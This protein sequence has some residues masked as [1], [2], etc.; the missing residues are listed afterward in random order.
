MTTEDLDRTEESG[1]ALRAKLEAEIAKNKA[2]A[3]V[4]AS[5]VA[6][7]H[8]YVK[9]EDLAGV[10]PTQLVEKATEIE[11]KRAAEREELL[12]EVLQERGLAD[13]KLEEI[14]G[15]KSESDGAADRIASLGQ[16]NGA[17]ARRDPVEG[18]FGEDRIRAAITSKKK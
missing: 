5:V 6:S 9:P 3:E 11:A 7:S 1:S 18:A 12:R 2:T 4:L 13:E 15:S 10:D 8:K 16:L 17:P 14:I